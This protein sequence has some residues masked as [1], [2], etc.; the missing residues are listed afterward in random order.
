MTRL[1]TP[2]ALADECE[3]SA[4]LWLNEVKTRQQAAVELRRLDAVNRQ[5]L[6]ALQQ[7]LN[8]TELVSVGDY[9]EET[10]DIAVSKARIVIAAAK[11]SE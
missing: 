8:A 10:H 9:N 1:V 2:L 6:E 3:E 5:L 4:E 7:L 11:E